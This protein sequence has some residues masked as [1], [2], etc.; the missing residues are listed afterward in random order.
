[1][2][3]LREKAKQTANETPAC[4]SKIMAVWLDRVIADPDGSDKM[5]IEGRT[6]L[7]R[8]DSRSRM[9]GWLGRLI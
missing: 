7:S 1:M 2:V 5:V 4:T 8:E 6:W 9:D 3:D